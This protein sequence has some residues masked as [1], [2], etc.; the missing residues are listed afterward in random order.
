MLSECRLML[1]SMYCAAPAP[2]FPGGDTAGGRISAHRGPLLPL[3]LPAQ[4]DAHNIRLCCRA[5]GW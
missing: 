5:A 4:R 1:L 3:Q 2:R